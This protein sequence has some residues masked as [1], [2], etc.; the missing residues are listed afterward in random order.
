VIYLNFGQENTKRR[1]PGG[2]KVKDTAFPLLGLALLAFAGL[3]GLA[4]S[5]LAQQTV[6]ACQPPQADEY[7]LLVVSQTE[8]SQQ[9]IQRTLPENTQTTVCRYLEDT[10]TRIAGFRSIEDAKGWARYVQE[11]VGLSAFVVRP[12]STIPSTNSLGYNPQPLGQGYAVLVDYF[13]QPE[14]AS[15]VRQ[16]L[17]SNVGL[18]SYGQRP[19]L[20]AR[21]TT[22]ERE[23]NSTL[24][25]LSDRGFWS[26]VVDSRRVTL[27]KPVVNF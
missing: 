18:V 17:G 2:L 15:Q 13:N 22:S 1:Y 5:A 25:Q 20:L 19:Y 3:T 10:V 26:M 23:A 27:L 7:L 12:A 14:L 24:R 6:S 9:Q 21:Y 16:L 4:D 8:E 11:I